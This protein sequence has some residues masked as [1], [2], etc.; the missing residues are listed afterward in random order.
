ML[1]TTD[2]VNIKT[3]KSQVKFHKTLMRKLIKQTRM[4]SK[5]KIEDNVAS[6]PK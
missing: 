6:K 5:E 2:K 4:D 1:T 3:Q